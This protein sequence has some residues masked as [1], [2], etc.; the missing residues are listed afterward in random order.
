MQNTFRLKNWALSLYLDWATGHSIFDESYSR[1][2]YGTFTNN[3]ALA[4]DVL[5]AWKKPGDKTKY[6]KFYANDSN[7]GND[8]YNRR[9]TNTF[10]YKGDYLCLREITLQYSL[11][12]KLFTKVGLKGVTLTVS[13]NNLCYF[14]EVKGISPEM[15]SSTTYDGDVFYN[16]PPI[17]RFSFG[18]RLIF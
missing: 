16:Y 8:N 14:T 3:Y 13:G 7:W 11:P 18:V 6:A 5:K 1:Y 17:R 4:K 9:A 2:F 12:S 10:T 15:G